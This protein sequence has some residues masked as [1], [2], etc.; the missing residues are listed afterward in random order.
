MSSQQLP[1]INSS[2]STS[3]HQ[4]GVWRQVTNWQPRQ[5]ASGRIE[6]VEAGTTWFF[7][8]D[9][10]DKKRTTEIKETSPKQRNGGFR[11]WHQVINWQPRQLPSGRIEYSKAGMKWVANRDEDGEH[12]S[13]VEETS[14]MESYYRNW[15]PGDGELEHFDKSE[16]ERGAERERMRR[17][18]AYLP[19]IEALE[20]AVAQGDPPEEVS[21]G[22]ETCYSPY[23][24]DLFDTYRSDNNDDGDQS[25]NDHDDGGNGDKNPNDNNDVEEPSG[26]CQTVNDADIIIGEPMRRLA[27]GP[28]PKSPLFLFMREGSEEIEQEGEPKANFATNQVLTKLV[29]DYRFT[30]TMSQFSAHPHA[31]E[32]GSSCFR[33]RITPRYNHNSRRAGDLMSSCPSDPALKLPPLHLPDMSSSISMLGRVS[34]PGTGLHSSLGTALHFAPAALPPSGSSSRSLD[35]SLIQDIFNAGRLPSTCAVT[36]WPANNTSAL[37]P[38]SAPPSISPGTIVAE[39][40]R[41]WQNEQNQWEPQATAE[42][43]SYELS[44]K[45]ISDCSL[46]HSSRHAYLPAAMTMT[47]PVTNAASSTDVSI[48]WNGPALGY[49]RPGNLYPPSIMPSS[50]Q[51]QGAGENIADIKEIV[52]DYDM[53]MNW[54][55]KNELERDAG[56]HAQHSNATIRTLKRRASTSASANVARKKS[57]KSKQQ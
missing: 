12:S 22:W 38:F 35:Y 34:A 3:K 19:R 14:S 16:E 15:E 25:E 9:E 37:I 1:K 26:V 40:Q 46:L 13:H 56:M 2:A 55:E 8:T 48:F 29:N 20:A 18:E 10:D 39:N 17:R 50:R 49:P 6:Y 30:S 11:E 7:D 24:V 47:D 45:L 31:R 21:G 53:E 33:L 54:E 52:T 23:P 43:R 36:S 57:T 51:I 5:L 42:Q 27:L 44:R 4:K 28:Q 32:L 41:R